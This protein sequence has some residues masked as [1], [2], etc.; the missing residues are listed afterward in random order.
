M[1]NGWKRKRLR[2]PISYRGPRKEHDF[3]AAVARSSDLDSSENGRGVVRHA[4]STGS[5]VHNVYPFTHQSIVKPHI[6][7]ETIR[8]L[9]RDTHRLL[10]R[11][12]LL[13]EFG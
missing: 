4:I 11:E 13:Q 6:W 12:T 2:N 10:L 8:L 5:K 9:L 3:R 1:T 7:R